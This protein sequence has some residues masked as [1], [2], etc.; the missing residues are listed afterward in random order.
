MQGEL[1]TN[2]LSAS[3]Q[4][5]ESIRERKVGGTALSRKNQNPKSVQHHSNMH[6]TE[7]MNGLE[8]KS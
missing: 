7:Y 4:R 3:G 2:Q 8:L 5:I 6:E 1:L